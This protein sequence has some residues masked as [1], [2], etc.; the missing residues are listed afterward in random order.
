[1][2][3]PGLLTTTVAAA[4]T[5]PEEAVMV[6]V[7][8]VSAV[9]RPFEL[10]DATPGAL[11]LHVIGAPLMGFPALFVS[12]AVYWSICPRAVIVS[13]VE[14]STIFDGLLVT[15]MMAESRRTPAT[16]WT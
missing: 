6:V 8:F 3:V 12:C 1:M 4:C 7:P 10:A 11:E 5:E 16:A 14:L 15:V 2:S 9:T 13:N